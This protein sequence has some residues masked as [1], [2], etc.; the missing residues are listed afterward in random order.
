MSYL[1]DQEEGGG[2]RAGGT[3]GHTSTLSVDSTVATSQALVFSFA[4][5][6]LVGGVVNLLP[7]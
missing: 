2:R 6:E 1:R 7:M 4:Q 5:K 3:E